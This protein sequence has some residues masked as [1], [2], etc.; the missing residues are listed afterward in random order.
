MSVTL[1][2]LEQK[3]RHSADPWEFRTSAYEQ[4]KFVAT[5]DALARPSY[6]SALELGCGNGALAEKLSPLCARYVGVDG[7]KRAVEAAREA[8]PAARFSQR[9][10]PCDLPQ[11]DHDLIILSEILYFLDDADIAKLAAQITQAWPRA[12]IICVTYLGPTGHSLQ[13]AE[14]LDIFCGALGPRFQFENIKT[15]TGYRIDRRLC[16]EIF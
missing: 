16:Q 7:V 6:R 9:L 4:E 12:E 11:G 13:G 1:A 2:E 15:T 8:V 14:A 10:F 5:R 3:Y